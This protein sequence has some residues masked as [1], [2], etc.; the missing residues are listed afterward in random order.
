MITGTFLLGLLGLGITLIGG[1]FAA[2]GQYQQNQ[3]DEAAL[4]AQLPVY[5][6][7]Q[8]ALTAQLKDIEA[9][10]VAARQTTALNEMQIARQGAQAVGSV[11]ATAGTGNVGGASVL[12]REMGIQRQVGEEITRQN[13]QLGTTLGGL[14]VNRLQTEASLLQSNVNE[15]NTKADI[16]FLQK[17]GWMN[18]AAVA[19]GAGARATQQAEQIDWPDQSLATESY[20]TDAYTQANSWDRLW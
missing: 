14:N 4:A 13:I 18:V 9:N 6:A 7:Q 19:L 3:A 10:K 11:K 17:Y 8:A 2:V 12:R 1:I 20:S 16:T 5:D 15:T